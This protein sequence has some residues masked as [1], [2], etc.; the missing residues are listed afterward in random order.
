MILDDSK[1]YDLDDNPDL[2]RQKLL[3]RMPGFCDKNRSNYRA[4]QGRGQRL[5]PHDLESKSNR[6]DAYFCFADREAIEHDFVKVMWLDAHGECLLI[7]KI[8]PGEFELMTTMFGEGFSMEEAVNSYGLHESD[9][10]SSEDGEDDDDEGVES[11]EGEES[12]KQKRKRKSGTSAAVESSRKRGRVN[13]TTPEYKAGYK[14]GYDA[15]INA[16][17]TVASEQD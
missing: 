7:N 16:M 1:L 12:T 4:N 14:A 11:D 10:N 3:E 17:I 5:D 15:G 6:M 13:K 8:A 2:L 9:M